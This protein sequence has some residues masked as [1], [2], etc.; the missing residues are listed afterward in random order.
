[1]SKVHQR[2]RYT[3]S[4][5]VPLAYSFAHVAS[6]L[7]TTDNW[8]YW[9][10]LLLWQAELPNTTNH[11]YGF[12]NANRLRDRRHND[13]LNI[14]TVTDKRNYFIMHT[15]IPDTT[16]TGPSRLVWRAVWSGHYGDVD[17]LVLLFYPLI[18]RFYCW[19]ELYFD[20][21]IN[22]ARIVCLC[23]CRGSVC[24][25]VPSSRLTPLLQLCCCG[26]AGRRY[27]SRLLHGAQQRGVQLANAGSATLS[28]YAVAEHGFVLLNEGRL[29]GCV[30]MSEVWF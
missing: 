12:K 15:V 29:I 13:A 24:L 19:S 26:P 21:F 3:G 4:I 8:F 10:H 30:S 20:D 14:I 18:S 6:Q 16:E 1:L 22:A 27:I 17:W 7:A 28:A 25:S 9:A 2:M 5:P 23:I 11:K